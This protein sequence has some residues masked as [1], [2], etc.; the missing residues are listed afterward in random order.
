LSSIKSVNTINRQIERLNVQY[1]EMVKAAEA[2]T[3]FQFNPKLFDDYSMYHTLFMNFSNS[4]I[5]KN[6]F[7]P[8]NAILQANQLTP[9]NSDDSE[10]L[11]EILNNKASWLQGLL[12]FGPNI[13]IYV[14][15]GMKII[16]W[17]VPVVYSVAGVALMCAPNLIKW[18]LDSSKEKEEAFP[19]DTSNPSEWISH[20]LQVISDKYDAIRILIMAQDVKPE[21]LPAEYRKKEAALYSRKTQEEQFFPNEAL[22][23]IR[24]IMV[25]CTNA[26]YEIMD[27]L[28]SHLPVSS[29]APQPQFSAVPNQ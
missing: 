6:P 9:E 4:L 7:L 27:D 16:P 23:V 2:F 21:R 25:F 17:L 18:Y 11:S 28:I 8:N 19:V 14:L 26:Y 10:A 15:A 12:I 1:D 5:T 3:A 22:T 29:S 20:D 13:A 24:K